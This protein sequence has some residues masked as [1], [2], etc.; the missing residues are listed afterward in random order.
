[1]PGGVTTREC[2]MYIHTQ[3]A[4]IHT[5]IH[6]TCVHTYI[7]HFRLVCYATLSLS[8]YA[9]QHFFLTLM[10]AAGHS[11]YCIYHSSIPTLAPSR[12]RCT[13]LGVAC[14]G[15]SVATNDP[16]WAWQQSSGPLPG[17]VGMVVV[18]QLIASFVH[19]C[20]T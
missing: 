5:Y 18:G 2:Y 1:M 13:F 4:Y 14:S 15:I 11:S 6:M 16:G 19:A 12:T 17:G 8:E 3:R 7:Y 20:L 9:S 10:L